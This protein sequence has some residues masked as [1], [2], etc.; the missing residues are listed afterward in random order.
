MNPQKYNKEALYQ[1]DF[2]CD[3]RLQFHMYLEQAKTIFPKIANDEWLIRLFS[4]CRGVGEKADFQYFSIFYGKL[5]FWPTPLHPCFHPPNSLYILYNFP[6][7]LK[8]C[9]RNMIYMGGIYYG[10]GRGNSPSSTYRHICIH[11]LQVGWQ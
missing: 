9:I 4:L 1:E 5:C 3:E 11:T 6:L 10:E 2:S 8:R 7:D